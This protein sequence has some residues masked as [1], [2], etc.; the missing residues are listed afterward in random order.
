MPLCVILPPRYRPGPFYLIETW[1]AATA[2][3]KLNTH[4]ASFICFLFLFCQLFISFFPL[5]SASRCISSVFRRRCSVSSWTRRWM[6]SLLSYTCCDTFQHR[7]KF[8]KSRCW[9]APLL[10]QW[11]NIRDYPSL[12]SLPAEVTWSFSPPSCRGGIRCLSLQFSN[13]SPDPLPGPAAWVCVPVSQ[14]EAK[15]SLW[16]WCLSSCVSRGRCCC[17]TEAE[18]RLCG[19]VCRRGRQGL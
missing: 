5:L 9:K 13:W 2:P 19:F 4:V 16:W 7:F 10:F 1:V 12:H 6:S 15:P 14:S 18:M 3:W 17:C 8:N 11:T